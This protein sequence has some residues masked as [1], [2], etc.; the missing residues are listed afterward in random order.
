[1]NNR[2]EEII[3]MIQN[4]SSDPFLWYALA[5]EYDKI[6]NKKEV[7]DSFDRLLTHFPDYLPTYYQAAHFF[8]EKGNIEK[9]KAAFLK[10]I[11]LAE[12]AQDI[13]TAQELRN[14]YQNFLIDIDD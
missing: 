4:D 8:W 3:Q 7:E 6:G 9:A 5:L 2:I 14:G 10:G 12:K 11:E 1:M 13:K